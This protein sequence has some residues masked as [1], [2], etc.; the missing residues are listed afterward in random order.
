MIGYVEQDAPALSGTIRS[1]LLLAAP[2]ASD[3]RCREVLASVNLAALIDQHPKGLDAPV[4]QNGVTLSGGERQRLAIARAL[5]PDPPI[6]LLDESTS[7]LDSRN[8]RLMRSALDAV[9]ERRTVL[10][11]AHR[12]STI[13][14]ADVIL[15]MDE[16]RIVDRGTHA[17]LVESSVCIESSRNISYSCEGRRMW[18]GSMRTLRDVAAA[19]AVIAL[20]WLTTPVDAGPDRFLQLA[21]AAIAGWPV[22]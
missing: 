3:R 14:D 7:S 1:N 8:E 2:D 20:F 11:V 13:I 19:T 15:V 6:L 9:A 22:R 17:D 4:G 21:L 18:G 5:I 10:V 12:L 16:G